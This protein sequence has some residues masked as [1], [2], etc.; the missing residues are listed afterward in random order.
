MASLSV[1]NC[2]WQ[3]HKRCPAAKTAFQN[4]NTSRTHGVKSCSSQM[5]QVY[6]LGRRI[7]V[8]CE[9]VH[10]SKF[11]WSRSA[12]EQR[13]QNI[14]DWEKS[15]NDC[16][17]FTKNRWKVHDYCCA[18]EKERKS[19]RWLLYQ[20]SSCASSRMLIMT[21]DTMGGLK[22]KGYIKKGWNIYRLVCTLVSISKL[23]CF[24][25][26]RSENQ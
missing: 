19:L 22:P 23:G 17:S 10:W 26:K 5:P 12:W 16:N 6:F 25:F 21:F 3:V 2:T 15:L 1:P 24:L 13:P 20:I 4:S 8:F 18:I 11:L 7:N 14:S 9:K